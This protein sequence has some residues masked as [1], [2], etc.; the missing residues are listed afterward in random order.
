MI[1]YLCTMWS[2][3]DS[4]FRMSWFFLPAG[5]VLGTVFATTQVAATVWCVQ[6]AMSRG[7]RAGLGAGLGIALAQGLS[8]LLASLIVFT[9][10]R[11][12]DH[13]DW[14]Y[15]FFAGGILAAMGFAVVQS[16]KIQTLEYEGDLRRFLPIFGTSFSI[17]LTMPMLLLGYVAQMIAC[18]LHLRAHHFSNAPLFGLGVVLG[19]FAWAV[20]FVLLAW[21]FGHR[22]EREITLKSMNKLR[23]LAV[24]VLTGL[25]VIGVLPMMGVK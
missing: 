16:R 21:A 1:H 13:A 23:F 20:Y 3:V 15:R 6:I 25:F 8:S 9:L 2:I 17:M 10:A 22:V 7:L 19:S 12:T 5:A 11:W 14:G 4:S 18:S 24:A